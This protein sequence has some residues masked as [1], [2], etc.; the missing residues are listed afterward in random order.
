MPFERPTLS[1]LIEQAQA[2]VAT[3]LNLPSLLRFS[4]E[5]ALATALAGQAQG[6]FG[7]LDWI[8]LQATPFTAQDEYLE[9]WAALVGIYRRAAAAA[10]G[11]ATFTGTTGTTLPAGTALTAAGTGAGYVTTAS[12]LVAAGEVTVPIEATTRGAA[13]NAAAGAGLLLAAPIAG[14]NGT[15]V[16]AAALTGGADIESDDDLR[17][18]MLAAYQ[19]PPQGGAESDYVR[20]ASEVPGVTRAWA[21]RNEQGP[22]TVAVYVMFDDTSGFPVGTDGAAAGEWRAP[23]A[24]GDQLA[25]A[26]HIWPLQPVTALVRVYAPTPAPVSFVIADINDAA[27]R[28]AITAALAEV[29][30]EKGRPG[31]TL[32][33]SDFFGALDAVP[34]LTRYTVSLPTNPVVAVIGA[35]P[36]LGTI[37]WL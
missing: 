29:I 26:Q 15:G 19:A 25:V 18:R 13:S 37:S 24:S 11:T 17:G 30:R 16:A 23:T 7:Y 10:A 34:G 1:A 2:D 4:P 31:G 32:Y 20:W 21:R 12:G 5:R 28:P 35:V 36:V 22:G 6:L 8:A 9:A 27:L 3:S 33:P 14:I